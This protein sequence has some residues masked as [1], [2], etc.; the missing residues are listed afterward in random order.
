MKK[1]SVHDPCGKLTT[2][3]SAGDS[4][5][6]IW[7]EGAREIITNKCSLCGMSVACF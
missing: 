6:R 7:T 2:M 5:G 3:A 1:V 4:W